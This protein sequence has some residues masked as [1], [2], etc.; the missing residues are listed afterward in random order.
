MQKRGAQ[1]EF[2][3]R[4]GR[5]LSLICL[6]QNSSRQIWP[7]EITHIKNY[8]HLFITFGIKRGEPYSRAAIQ[9]DTQHSVFASGD[10][11][12][13]IIDLAHQR[14]GRAQM[15]YNLR[16]PCK[17]TGERKNSHKH[18]QWITITRLLRKRQRWMT[19]SPHQERCC[20]R[21]RD[22]NL[23]WQSIK[24]ANEGHQK[25]IHA[26]I[27][28]SVCV[29]NVLKELLQHIFECLCVEHFSPF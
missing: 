6:G 26:L 29:C 12:H 5:L 15:Q 28:I 3:F 8:I 14:A 7:R 23:E 22:E 11:R 1:A 20:C 24:K 10:E 25:I 13:S 16:R 21:S 19:R 9:L 27:T 2:R 4:R 18:H 17:A